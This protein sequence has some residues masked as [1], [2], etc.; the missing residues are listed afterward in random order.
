MKRL[1]FYLT[2]LNSLALF[3]Q[4]KINFKSLDSLE[5]SADWYFVS[6]NAPSILLCHQAQSS[7]GEY[8]NIT[9]KLNELGYN[10]LA[11]DLRVGSK[12]QG[13]LN[14]TNAR[15]LAKKLPLTY[16]DAEKDILAGIE[17][18]YKK[19]NKKPILIFGSSYTASFALK[20]GNHN[21]KIAAIIAFSPGEYFEKKLNVK[22]TLKD[23]DKPAFVTSSLGEAKII[24]TMFGDLYSD[25]I[26]IYVPKGEGVHGA[27]ALFMS[28]PNH[29]EYWGAL[30]KFFEQLNEKK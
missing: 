13:I 26:Y 2:L 5:I 23:F 28:N 8:K 6:E 10:C 21:P 22:E 9:P 1:L 20:N 17:Y 16:L 25:K 15:A 19:S 11:I 27:K 14:E 3:A 30:K 18:L 12:M 4:E 24:R 7:R 29:D